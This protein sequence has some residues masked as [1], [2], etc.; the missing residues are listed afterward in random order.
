MRRRP[1]WPSTACRKRPRRK[2]QS[3]LPR[4]SDLLRLNDAGQKA[5]LT[6]WLH[7][8][9]TA[10]SFEDALAARDKLQRAK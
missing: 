8:C 2:A 3:A 1:S 9:Y 5:L 6:D 4:L 10:Q 7:G